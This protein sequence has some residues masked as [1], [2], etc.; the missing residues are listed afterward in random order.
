M[1]PFRPVLCHP[2]IYQ[3]AEASNGTASAMAGQDNVYI[4]DMLILAE[5]PEQ[6]SQHLK[7][8]LLILQALGLLSIKI[9]LC[10]PQPSKS[11]F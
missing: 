1:P 6:A 4:D 7:N 2:H 5:T 10:S 3:S 8:L 11:S 9:N